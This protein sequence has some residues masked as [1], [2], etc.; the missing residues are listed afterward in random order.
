MNR[1]LSAVTLFMF[2]LPAAA[3]AGNIGGISENLGAQLLTVTADVGYK[4]RD[5]KYNG[6]EDELTSRSF[7]IKTTYGTSDDLDVYVKLGFADIQDINVPGTGDYTG[8]LGTLFGGGLKYRLLGRSGGTSITINAD[9]ETFE[10][11]DSG[12]KADYLEYHV[13]AVVSNKSGNFTPFGGIKLSDAE[14]DFG[15]SVEYDADKNFGL[16]GGVDYFVNPNV[17]FTGEV[18]I[19]DENTLYIGVGYNF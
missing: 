6:N 17:Y 4:T 14:V 13:A 16:F 18:H 11:K 3:S 7:V 9:F 10:S 12:R 1:I 15:G 19:F 5:V 8:A 2:L